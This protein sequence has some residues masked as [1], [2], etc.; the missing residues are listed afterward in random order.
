METIWDWVTVLAFAGLITLFLQRSDE[1]E[2]RDKL[3]QY[4]PPS[5]GCAVTNYFGNEGQ[6]LLAVGVAAVSLIYVFAVLKPSLPG[7]RK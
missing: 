3:W 2:P 5:I 7:R 6:V 4:F 1:S